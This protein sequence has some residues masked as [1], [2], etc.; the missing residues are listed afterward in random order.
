MTKT[1]TRTNNTRNAQ[2]KSH[3]HVDPIAEMQ[4]QIAALTQ[5]VT[6]L[7][8][9]ALNA[10]AHAKSPARDVTLP[11]TKGKA[12]ASKNKPARVRDEAKIEAHNARKLAITQARDTW[13]KREWADCVKFAAA[14]IRKNRKA[15]TRNANITD[16]SCPRVWLST[17]SNQGFMAARKTHAVSYAD[18]MQALETA[19]K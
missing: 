14:E 8:A 2:A 11:P 4:A 16:A 9:P 19:S 15:N 10:Q 17:E 18:A 6:A 13:A 12:K 3:A 1:N 7:L 5:A